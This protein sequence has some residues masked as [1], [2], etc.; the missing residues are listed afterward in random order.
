MAPLNPHCVINRTN[1]VRLSCACPVLASLG[2]AVGCGG[3]EPSNAP[4]VAAFLTH[5]NRLACTFENG[6]SDEDGTVV[7]YAWSFGDG[8]T[9][10]DASPSHSYTAPGGTFTVSVAVTDNDGAS[11][12]I[13]RSLT[14]SAYNLAPTV[15]F[16][17]TCVGLTCKFTDESTDPDSGDTIDGHRWDFGDSRYST[18]ANPYHTYEAPGGQ[19]TVTLVVTD[20]HGASA[21]TSDPVR[22]IRDSA[23]DRSG[24]YQ[25]VG[26]EGQSGRRSRY[27]I[28]P[29]GTFAYVEESQAGQR[30]L[31]GRWSFAANWGGWAIEPGGVIILD[32][33]GVEA[34]EYCGEAYGY[35]L[36]NGYLGIALC[37]Q[38]LDEGLTEGLY[39]S[40]PS[41]E[42]PT[43]PPPQAGQIA[44]VREGKI[45]QANTDGTGVVQ[46]SAGPN[47][48][49]PAW[50]PDG[51]RIAF[52]RQDTTPGIY[53]MNADGTNLG[54]RAS[55]QAGFATAPTWSPDGAWIAFAC[56]GDGDWGLCKVRA[57]DDGTT[58]V[59]FFPRRGYLADAAWSP[60]GSH[61]AFI[62]DWNMFDFWFDAWL[63]S[64]DG[65]QPE[66]LREHTPL[67]PNPDQQYQPAWSPDGQRIALVECPSWSW[68]T[69]SSS[70]IAIMNADG[71]GLVRL[72]TT[73]GLAHPTW[74]PDG[75]TIAFAN[76][77]AN[78][79]E[80]ISA[81][82]RERGRIIENGSSPAWRP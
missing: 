8:G 31:T 3:T 10:T 29:D 40:V 63:V 13:S 82:G 22:A 19:F 42:S 52:F 73:T 16:S 30:T 65:S 70:A 69:C 38:L 71:S 76:T 48:A 49:S 12:T 47:D 15:A 43:L 75:R 2:L 66:A 37:Q 41:P 7:A 6:S 24:I 18:D 60:D 79:I 81:D 9:S 54:R 58:P 67:T 44:F 53:I 1:T 5:C 77:T 36:Q 27:E 59:T 50:S 64:A 55:V 74:S 4:P 14:V 35:F 17:T 28:H 11:A 34:S 25:R 80:W 68:N 51:R 20:N 32:F 46:L 45:F 33:D 72:T 57:A 39:T 23:P 78:A 26:A 21:H 62:S 61:I 56:F